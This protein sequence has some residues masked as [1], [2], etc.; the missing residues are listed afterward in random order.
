MINDRW[1]L[2]TDNWQLTS[3]VPKCPPMSRLKKCLHAAHPPNL[4][5][6]RDQ[7]I[8]RTKV[9]PLQNEAISLIPDPISRFFPRKEPRSVS[10]HRPANSRGPRLKSPPLPRLC[11][12]IFA[13][14]G[15]TRSKPCCGA[16]ACGASISGLAER[17]LEVDLM[18]IYDMMYI[19]IILILRG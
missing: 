4:S 1:Q 5:Q 10:P 13:L 12:R 19:S 14:G 11:R 6:P 17:K 8:A 3:D 16:S 15:L 18:S 7:K 9:A 2:T